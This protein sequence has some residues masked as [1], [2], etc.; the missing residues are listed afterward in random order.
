MGLLKDSH[1][2]KEPDPDNDPEEAEKKYEKM[3]MKMGR[4]FIHKDDF[5]AIM[6]HLIRQIEIA[7]P[8]ASLTLRN[9]PLRRN[10][11][12]MAKATLYKEYIEED[13]DGVKDFAPFDLAIIE[14]KDEDDED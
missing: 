5:V 11:N 14:E 8:T 1:D 13:K 9:V 2:G 12:A 7:M 4:D 10:A 6:E 3:Y